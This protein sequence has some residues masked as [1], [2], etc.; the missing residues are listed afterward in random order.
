MVKE[1][2]L[3][4]VSGAGH[5]LAGTDCCER[6]AKAL[7]EAASNALLEANTIYAAHD[8]PHGHVAMIEVRNR[9]MALRRRA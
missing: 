1:D 4:P 3:C 7:R 2:M 9:A 5:D 6:I 8:V